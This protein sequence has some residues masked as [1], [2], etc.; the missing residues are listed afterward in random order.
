MY[1]KNQNSSYIVIGL[2]YQYL[3]KIC[4]RKALALDC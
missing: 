1:V 4:T 3:Q 2:M